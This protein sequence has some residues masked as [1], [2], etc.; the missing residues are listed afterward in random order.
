MNFIKIIR[1]IFGESADF[2]TKQTTFICNQFGREKTISIGQK[3]FC[4]YYHESI[5]KNLPF[6]IGFTPPKYG[7]VIGDAGIHKGYSYNKNIDLQWLY[8]KF[9]EYNR[10]IA[11]PIDCIDDAKQSIEATK[12]MIETQ[13][14]ISFQDACARESLKKQTIK[15]EL[16]LNT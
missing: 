11:I 13:A 6:G 15:G 16:F 9:D 1:R 5:H 14:P 7:V 10:N 12:H 4:I 8:V 2:T 3:V